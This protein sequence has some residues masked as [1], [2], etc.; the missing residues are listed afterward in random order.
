MLY[1]I[2]KS[3]EIAEPKVSVVIP[4]YNVI[5]Y[6]DET[7]ESLLNQT[8]KEVEIV[9]VDDGS[10][11]GSLE[12]IIELATEH[13]NI[14]VVKEPNAGPGTA[15]NNGLDVARGKY[16]SFVDSDDVLPEK[17]LEIMY[18]AAESEQVGVVTGISV[19]FNSSRSWF[20]GGHFKKGV[21]KKRS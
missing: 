17:A 9:L 15:R 5:S 7:I 3:A 20:I 14:C 11:D 16:I 21:F 19:S 8:L 12:R 18:H 13:Q 4:V 1:E 6:I 2:V 10:S